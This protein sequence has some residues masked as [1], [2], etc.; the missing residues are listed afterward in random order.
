MIFY[1]DEKVSREN[2]KFLS[3][4]PH[5]MMQKFFNGELAQPRFG[6]PNRGSPPESR[7]RGIHSGRPEKLGFSGLARAMKP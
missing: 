2:R 3:L 6:L 7:S 4:Q 1:K 5:C